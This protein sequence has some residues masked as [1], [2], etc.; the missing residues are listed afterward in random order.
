MIYSAR[1]EVQIT[2]CNKI[3]STDKFKLERPPAAKT[4]FHSYMDNRK[5]QTAEMSI[6]SVF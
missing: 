4:P 2:E 3:I 6:V 5:V 1:R